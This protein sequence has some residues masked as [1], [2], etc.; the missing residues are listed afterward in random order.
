MRIAVRKDSQR[1]N[2]CHWGSV[3][4]PLPKHN[5]TQH[6]TTYTSLHII[7]INIHRTQCESLITL[8]HRASP[9]KSSLCWQ[10]VLSTHL[11]CKLCAAYQTKLVIYVHINIWCVHLMHIGTGTILHPSSF[12]HTYLFVGCRGSTSSIPVRGANHG[13]TGACDAYCSPK[14]FATE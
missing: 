8:Y 12:H 11:W 4:A 3:Y 7:T 13:I 10:Q 6:N 2:F 5:T 14:G 1:N 9:T